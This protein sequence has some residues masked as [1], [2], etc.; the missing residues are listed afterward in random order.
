M[1]KAK[2][3]GAKANKSFP[4]TS[5]GADGKWRQKK[6]LGEKGTGVKV[7]GITISVQDARKI[8]THY[9]ARMEVQGKIWLM[10]TGQ[11]EKELSRFKA[12]HKGGG[13]Y[14]FTAKAGRRY[15]SPEYHIRGITAATAGRKAASAAK[16]V[17]KA[18]EKMKKKLSKLKDHYS[19]TA[20]NRKLGRVGLPHKKKEKKAAPKNKKIK[21]QTK[22]DKNIKLKF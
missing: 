12:T 16:K 2:A 9:N 20:A 5:K 10:R 17:A 13:K 1:V 22:K 21:K 7:D 3:G 6:A 8:L 19:D 11:L 14:V 4:Y 15:T 18:D